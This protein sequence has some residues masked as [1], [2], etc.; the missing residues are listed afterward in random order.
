MELAKLR[1]DWASA[2]IDRLEILVDAFLD[3]KPCEILTRMKRKG[4]NAFF[5][6]ELHVLSQPP[7][8]ISFALGDVV[9]NLRAI[10]DNLVWGVGKVFKLSDRLDLKFLK[11]EP[12]FLNCYVPKINKLPQPIYDWIESIQL[13]HRGNKKKYDYTLHRLWNWDKHRTPVVVNAVAVTNTLGESGGMLPFN[14]MNFIHSSSRKDK[15][16]IVT[17]HVPWEKRGDFK[18]VFT[19]FVAFDES[20]PVS[21]DI[22]GQPQNII[23]YMRNVQRYILEKVIPKFE[24]YLSSHP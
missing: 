17:A 2:S 23:T 10:L 20:S 5:S 9:H 19:I 18:S 12:E 7:P 22:L 8:T 1:L 14:Q 4:E 24:P 3:T 15:Q 11:T 6:Y 13:Y 16:Q 21:M